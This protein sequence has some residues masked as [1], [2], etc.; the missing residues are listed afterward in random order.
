MVCLSIL[1]ETI[2]EKRSKKRE[3]QIRSGYARSGAREGKYMCI[4][5]IRHLLDAA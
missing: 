1:K 3:Q 2:G 4:F 5:F